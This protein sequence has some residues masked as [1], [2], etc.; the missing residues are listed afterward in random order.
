MQKLLLW[1]CCILP[2]LVVALI[3]T[4]GAFLL[5]WIVG[6]IVGYFIFALMVPLVSGLLESPPPPSPPPKMLSVRQ[7]RIASCRGFLPS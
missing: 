2:M 5:H 3:L 1:T 6:L 7:R 4:V